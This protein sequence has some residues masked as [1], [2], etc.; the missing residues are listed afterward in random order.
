MNTADVRSL[1]SGQWLF[2]TISLA[3]TVTVVAVVSFVGYCGEGIRE[4]LFTGLKSKRKS[5]SLA[6]VKV[7]EAEAGSDVSS[8]ASHDPR[9][10][11][12]ADNR[13][14]WKFW[15]K[16]QDDDGIMSARGVQRLN[17]ARF[18]GRQRSDSVGP[19]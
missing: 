5:K 14:K 13:S 8:A 19:V 17:Y 12:T 16:G 15:V 11:S 10:A 4:S 2:W 18:R 9:T 7:H 1:E 6:P 3:L